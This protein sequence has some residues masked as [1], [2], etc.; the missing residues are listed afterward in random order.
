[1]A[2]AKLI[3]T[4]YIGRLLLSL[5]TLASATI[6]RSAMGAQSPYNA[7]NAA[8]AASAITVTPVRGSISALFGSGGNI[9]AL[10]GPEGVFLVDT[11]LAVSKAKI[12]QALDR[13]GGGQIRYAVNTHWHWDHADGNGWIKASGAEI[14]ADPRTIADFGKTIAVP[15]WQHTFTPIAVKDRPTVAVTNVRTIKLNGEIIRVR[16]IGDG[17]TNGDVAVQ[18]ERANVLAL[19]DTFWNGIYPF[20]DYNVGGGINRAIQQTN[21]NISRANSQTLIVPGHGPVGGRADLIASRDM[22][23]AVR[24]KVKAMKAKGMSLQAVIDA[25]PTANYDA[26]WGKG[27]VDPMLF[28]T[29]VYRGV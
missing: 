20:I 9:T 1:M 15:E 12:R 24:K 28:V 26:K 27:V 29:L 21:V 4:P 14:M 11:G 16:A 10:V 8:A 25:R 3:P 22:L 7:L 6:P 13:L 2:V 17:H 5:G 18:F 19:G 23:V